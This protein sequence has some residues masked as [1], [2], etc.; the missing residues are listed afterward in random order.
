MAKAFSY[1]VKRDYGFAPNPFYGVLTLATCKPLIRKC[2]DVGDF[3]IGNSDKSHGNKLIYMAKV[4]QVMTFDQYWNDENFANKKPVM[5]GSLKKLYG[6][7]IYHHGAD[8]KWIQED[9]HHANNDGSINENNL[10]KDTNTTDRVLVCNE[11]FYLGR[12]MIDVPSEYS[13]CI[14]RNIGERHLDYND[15]QKLWDYLKTQYPNGGK[16]DHPSQFSRF[17]RYD[18]V[19]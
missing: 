2:A 1:V 18:G 19:S 10:R 14:Y 9:S 4:S 11:F 3:I 15:A 16:I 6:D 12:A 17:E 8:G 7:N 13:S 5:N